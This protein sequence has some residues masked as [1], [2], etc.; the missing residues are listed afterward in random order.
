MFITPRLANDEDTFEG[1]GIWGALSTWTDQTG[2][3]WLF[4][5]IWGPV[6][7]KAPKFPIANGDT[8]HG[9][10]M[11]FKV[12]LDATTRRPILE[13]AW[14][15]GDFNVP[16]PPV[17]ANGVLFALS[18]GEN[19]Q[20]TKEGGVIKWNKLTLLTNAER[21]GKTQRAK[22]YALDART[23]KALW[24]SGELIDSWTHFS[25]LAV[26]NGRIYAVD[27]KSQVYS[28]GLKEKENK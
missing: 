17:L 20:Q 11:A 7:K 8:P 2:Q 28:F 12:V 3:A 26:A 22:L 10:I 4:T 13:P 19:V 6:S 1:K 9:C 21:E 16:D 5:P 24:D 23:G 25:G 18:T 27:H 15:S 14:I